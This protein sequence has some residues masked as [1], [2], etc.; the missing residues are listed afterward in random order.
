MARH[1]FVEIRDAAQ[2]H[3][4]ITLVEILSPSNKRRGRDRNSYEA[5]QRQVLESDASLIE[6]D[7][8][9]A[10]RRILPHPHLEAAIARLEPRPDYVVLLSRAWERDEFTLGYIAF[11]FALRDPLPCIPTP[12][13]EGEPE[14]PLDLQAVF[15]STYDTGAYRR[16]MVDYSRPPKPPLSAEDAAWAEGLLRAL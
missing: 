16:G 11:P 14:P 5:K 3:K 10:G 8:L 4:L 2:D 13:K 7:L 15:R 6:I 9:R 1:H 12:L